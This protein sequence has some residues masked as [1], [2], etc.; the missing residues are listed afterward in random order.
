MSLSTRYLNNID[1]NRVKI[2]CFGEPD[3]IL[4]NYYRPLRTDIVL[5]STYKTTHQLKIFDEVIISVYKKI[6]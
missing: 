3:Y 1:R 4:N 5:N 6:K 2:S